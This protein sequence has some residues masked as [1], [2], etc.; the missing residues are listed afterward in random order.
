MQKIDGAAEQA[1]GNDKLRL[2]PPVAADNT[3]RDQEHPQATGRSL[4][5]SSSTASDEDVWR[6]DNPD[7]VIPSHPAVQMYFNKYRQVVIRQD[8]ALDGNEDSFIFLAVEN[9]DRFIAKLQ[10]LKAEA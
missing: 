8:G 5:T 4:A 7:V 9:I 6:G 2:V 1:V 3:E 10:Q